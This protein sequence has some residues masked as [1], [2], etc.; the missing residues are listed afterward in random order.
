MNAVLGHAEIRGHPDVGAMLVSRRQVMS[1]GMR[2]AR[3]PE[4]AKSRGLPVRST[5]VWAAQRL[6]EW[7]AP[8]GVKV[9]GRGLRAPEERAD[10]C[11]RPPD[12]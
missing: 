7:K 1:W 4:Q 12:T 6:R 5:T 9:R 8:A 3:P 2:R 10:R 11:T